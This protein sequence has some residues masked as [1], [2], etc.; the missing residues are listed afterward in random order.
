[1]VGASSTHGVHTI[2]ELFSQFK[3]VYPHFQLVLKAGNNNT[4]QNHVKDGSID[5]AFVG[6][7]DEDLENIVLNRD[8]VILA[9]P[10]NNKI[11]KSLKNSDISAIDF[12][13]FKNEPFILLQE[14]K[15]IR[16]I[17]DRAFK[18]YGFKPNIEYETRDF[19][20]A[21]RMAHIGLGCTFVTSKIKSA[22]GKLSLFELDRGEYLYSFL[23]TY[24]KDKYLSKPMHYFI[25]LAKE[26]RLQINRISY[27]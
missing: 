17:A 10:S 8:R 3:K 11:V 14:G 9:V 13:I 24:R 21:Y 2:P 5:F 4:L 18:D 26:L 6:N 7:V 25:E 15:A 23:L 22:S 27:P 20:T 1:M 19:D 16:K 12:K